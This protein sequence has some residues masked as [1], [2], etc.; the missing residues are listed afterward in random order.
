M[1]FLLCALS[2]AAGGR[3]AAGISI[4]LAQPAARGG[5]P[6][7]PGGAEPQR[8]AA[9]NGSAGG[10][11]A[12]RVS[13]LFLRLDHQEIAWSAAAETDGLLNKAATEEDS[14]APRSWKEPARRHPPRP[15]VTRFKALFGCAFLVCLVGTWLARLFRGVD[16]A[17]AAGGSGGQQAESAAKI[18]LAQPSR[19][20]TLLKA[21]LVVLAWMVFSVVF[22]V[23]N[24]YMFSRGG[25]PYPVTLTGMHMGS[26]YIVFGL[27]SWLPG[28]WRRSLMPDADKFIPTPL[29][30]KG[31]VPAAL[32]M[33]ICLGIGNL[34]FLY[35]TVAFIQMVKPVNI[36]VTSI[37]G[38]LWGLEAAT[39][40]HLCIA[41]LV[42][43]GVAIAASGEVEFSLMGLICQLAASTCEGLR[44][45]ILQG[46]MQ[47]SLKLDPLTTLYRFTPV[48]GLSL[49][50]LA[51]LIEG[52]V[53]WEGLKLPGLLVLNC[54]MAV[55]LNV[56]I[57]AVV[58]QTSAVVFVLAGVFKDIATI[59]ISA[60]MYHSPVTRQEILGYSLSLIGICL[61]KVYKDNLAIF[62]EHGMIAGFIRVSTGKAHT[63]A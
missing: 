33:A 21:C 53:D 11:E 51:C 30:I 32:L 20:Y 61:F 47:G 13:P 60:A 22:I 19:A 37:A 1:A 59:A 16:A 52:P 12:S 34:G 38:F 48:A 10:G 4:Q 57:A 9:A 18:A 24:K 40:T 58:H 28:E 54:L 39:P 29:Y 41:F 8:E 45:I 49:C 35:A 14:K 42:S 25:F 36:V 55:C 26:C 7:S 56:L 44:L 6:G 50:I 46:I 23:F 17:D 62:K 15:Q 5:H 31:L 63:M 2:L 3:L 27:I 43:G